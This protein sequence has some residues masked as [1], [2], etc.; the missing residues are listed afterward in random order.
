MGGCGADEGVEAEDAGESTAPVAV[1]TGSESIP[2]DAAC[3]RVGPECHTQGATVLA[4][5]S[6]RGDVLQREQQVQWEGLQVK[7]PEAEAGPAAEVLAS[8]QRTQEEDSGAEHC[9]QYLYRSVLSSIKMGFLF[10]ASSDEQNVQQ[11]LLIGPTEEAFHPGP[12]DESSGLHD[13]C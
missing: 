2:R 3:G 9:D 1:E 12:S 7:D 5:P 4:A 10:L 11:D 13:S 8:Q 6:R